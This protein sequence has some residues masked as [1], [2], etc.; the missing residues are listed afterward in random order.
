MKEQIVSK[1][2]RTMTTKKIVFRLVLLCDLKE[3]AY[4]KIKMDMIYPF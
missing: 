3:C 2:L 1:H 4:L